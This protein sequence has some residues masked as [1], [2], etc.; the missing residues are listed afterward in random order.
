MKAPNIRSINYLR[1]QI[2]L[3]PVTVTKA[4]ISD[5]MCESAW[6][7]TLKEDINL[8][9]KLK[10]KAGDTFELDGNLHRYGD[11]WLITGI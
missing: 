11:K 2:Y 9:G 5:T 10:L 6:T 4:D 8:G 3:F 1:K 7:I